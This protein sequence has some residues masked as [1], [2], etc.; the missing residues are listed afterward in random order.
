MSFLKVVGITFLVLLILGGVLVS[1]LE[2]RRPHSELN[3]S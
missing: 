1:L 2:S 3:L